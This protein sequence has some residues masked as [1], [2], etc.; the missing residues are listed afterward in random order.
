MSVN[1]IDL[2]CYGL[3]VED[4]IHN[5]TPARLY[6]FAIVDHHAVISASGALATQKRR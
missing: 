6:E 5:A 2:S 3:S 4:I 1:P